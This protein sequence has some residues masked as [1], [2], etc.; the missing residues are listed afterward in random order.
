M[1]VYGTLSV[2]CKFC[3]DSSFREQCAMMSFIDLA[4]SNRSRVRARLGDFQR[5]VS[6]MNSVIDKGVT[7]GHLQERGV[8]KRMMGIYLG[9]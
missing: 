1:V 5:A 6:D 9:R 4:R 8:L 3:I 7:Q 2:A